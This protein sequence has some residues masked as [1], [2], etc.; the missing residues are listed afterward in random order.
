M[1]T[2]FL[3]DNILNDKEERPD[4]LT[5]DTE[6]D[7]TSSLC[8]TPESN[9]NISPIHNYQH[10]EQQTLISGVNS[11]NVVG[12]E[13]TS[14]K[15]SKFSETLLRTYS[16]MIR[17]SECITSDDHSD[18]ASINFI[19]ICCTKCGH[20]QQLNKTR[21]SNNGI[22]NGA[23]DVCFTSVNDCSDDNNTDMDI[24]FK[25][26]KCESNEG[27]ISNQKETTTTILKDNTKPILKFSV[28]AILGNKE[29]CARVRHGEYI[30]SS[31]FSIIRPIDTPRAT[32]L[33]F[34]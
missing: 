19:E 8:G 17:N 13:N 28:S 30:A 25:C 33:H 1:S 21:N 11:A 5:T 32:E 14:N 2:A 26:D 4:S 24:D 29:E 22:N 6:S 10:R 18:E 12:G 23:N 34:H 16:T 27:V 31:L 15:V 9:E 3:V 7:E 20:F